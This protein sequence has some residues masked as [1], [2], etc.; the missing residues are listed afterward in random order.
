MQQRCRMPNPRL[1]LLHSVQGSK[2][3][4]YVMLS[5]FAVK[6]RLLPI[7]RRGTKGKPILPGSATLPQ[8]GSQLARL[9]QH[10]R[11]GGLSAG[12]WNQWSSKMLPTSNEFL[13]PHSSPSRAGTWPFQGGGAC[14]WSNSCEDYNQLLYVFT[15]L[16]F[17]HPDLLCR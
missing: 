6:A 16:S 15:S 8:Y 13:P 4:C 1:P 12:S 11:V 5:S 2:E 14:G 10:S 17:P 9:C 3:G 7:S